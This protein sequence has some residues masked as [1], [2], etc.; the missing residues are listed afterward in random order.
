MMKDVVSLESD[1]TYV[2]SR[3][4][5]KIKIDSCDSLSLESTLTL[6]NVTIPI[7]SVLN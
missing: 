4:Y 2:F 6:H 5:P 1:I 7:K 3:H